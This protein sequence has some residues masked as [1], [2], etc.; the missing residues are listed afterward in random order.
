MSALAGPKRAD[1]VTACDI[2]SCTAAFGVL[3]RRVPVPER[4]QKRNPVSAGQSASPELPP[5]LSA[6]NDGIDDDLLARDL[7]VQEGP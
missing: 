6:A 3:R 2:L 5:Q 7:V 1:S 4:D